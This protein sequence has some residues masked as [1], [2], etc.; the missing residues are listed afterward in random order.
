MSLVKVAV[1]SSEETVT[2]VDYGNGILG[3]PFIKPAPLMKKIFDVLPNY[4]FRED[5]VMLCTFPK[6]GLSF[7]IVYIYIYIII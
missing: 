4:S 6:T 5:D 1:G 2:L 3:P 7:Y